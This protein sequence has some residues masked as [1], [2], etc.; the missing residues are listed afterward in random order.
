M[1]KEII[2]I[3]R[4]SNGVIDVET[5]ENMNMLELF[6]VTKDVVA[7]VTQLMLSS[8]DEITSHK[9]KKALKEILC[10]AVDEGYINI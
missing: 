4:E 1:S 10:Q 2:K 9:H 7:I 6:N 8:L 3:K 5:V